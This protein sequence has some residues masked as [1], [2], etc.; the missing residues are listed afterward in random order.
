[1]KVVLPHWCACVVGPSH[2]RRHDT[3]Y[4]VYDSMRAS[5]RVPEHPFLFPN[6]PFFHPQEF[7]AMRGW[8]RTTRTDE[9]DVDSNSDDP[10]AQAMTMMNYFHGEEAERAADES[11]QLYLRASL[12]DQARENH[13]R[14]IEKLLRG[15]SADAQADRPTIFADQVVYLVAGLGCPRAL[16]DVLERRIVQA[17]GQPV[18]GSGFDALQA[19]EALRQADIVICD[20]RGGWEYWL[21]FEEEKIIGN[22]GWLIY[23][24]ARGK[25]SGPQSHLLHYPR[26]KGPVP[27]FDK[28]VR[29]W[30]CPASF[31]IVAIA[32]RRPRSPITLGTNANTS[33]ASSSSWV[34]TLT[35]SLEDRARTSRRQ[36]Y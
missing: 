19:D 1:M 31:Q 28:V 17:G 22:I 10:P 7:D 24:F 15:S 11:W 8:R 20:H 27:A 9:M 3:Q 16:L 33:S 4:R 6:P 30:Q 32:G 21:A 34:D 35:A 25:Y 23:C 36:Q 26:P 14:P 29:A 2:E 5:I 18:D 13:G 12:S